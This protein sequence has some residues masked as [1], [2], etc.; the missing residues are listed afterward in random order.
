MVATGIETN[1]K[2]LVNHFECHQVISEKSN[3]FNLLMKYC[4]LTKESV[5][6]H[7]PITFYVEVPDLEK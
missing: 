1:I 6:D 3:M 2:Q 7:T 4:D 5:F